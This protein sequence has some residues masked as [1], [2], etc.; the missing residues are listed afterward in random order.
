MTN[1]FELNKNA[2]K[3]IAGKDAMKQA[4]H[5]FALAAFPDHHAE[6]QIGM[7]I[8]AAHDIAREAG[9]MDM[10]VQMFAR[11]VGAEL[12]MVDV[13]PPAAAQAPANDKKP[14]FKLV[15]R[16]PAGTSTAAILANVETKLGGE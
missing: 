12:E 9:K 5:R 13:P 15:D 7:L 6:L 16:L 1:E 11:A 10:M 2:D 4:S 14:A 8:Q 3:L